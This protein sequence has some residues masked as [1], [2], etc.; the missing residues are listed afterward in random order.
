M[1]VYRLFFKNE[2][3]TPLRS[4]TL[5]GLIIQANAELHGNE[6]TNE[7]MKEFQDNTPPFRI[8]SAFPMIHLQEQNDFKYWFPV[9]IKPP[10]KREISTRHDYASIKKRKKINWISASILE[11]YLAGNL[12]HDEMISEQLELNKEAYIESVKSETTQVAIDRRSNSVKQGE[13]EKG[14]LFVSTGFVYN[15]EN[16]SQKRRTRINQGVFFVALGETEYIDTALRYL[17]H[18]GLG[19][20]HSTGKGHFK[21]DSVEFKELVRMSPKHEVGKYLLSL[22]HPTKEEIETILNKNSFYNIEM[23]QGYMGGTNLKTEVNGKKHVRKDSVAMLT[24]GS[25]LNTQRNPRGQI[26][27]VG[28]KINHSVYE[29]GIALTLSIGK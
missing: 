2:F 14:Q 10:K 19:A 13:N 24:E 3:R 5:W 7:L 21:F 26:L 20:D 1:R 11:K 17:S 23:R 9:P 28:D 16:K 27:K 6:W 29:N 4:D 25:I 18:R 12:K 22:Y 15:Y 8:S